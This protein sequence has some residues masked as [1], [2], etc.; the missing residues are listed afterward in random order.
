MDF[1]TRR[2]VR[3]NWIDL[4][5]EFA[6]PAMQ[7]WWIGGGPPNIQVSFVELMCGY[8]DDL[9]LT[10]GLDAAVRDGWMSAAEAQA[11]TEF[12]RR[13]ES[14]QPPSSAHDA[15]LADPAWA[16]V[17]DAARQAWFGVRAALDDPETI[18]VM[19]G[20]EAKWGRITPANT[21]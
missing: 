3:R 21:H 2:N 14:Y 20:L 17:V 4:L 16:D 1:A 5:Y 18:A 7:T 6:S 13:A 15:I 11:T 19:S 9:A 8:F 12:H 10:D